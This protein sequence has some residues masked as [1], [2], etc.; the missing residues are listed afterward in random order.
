MSLFR[1]IFGKTSEEA[2]TL[3][4]PVAPHLADSA[5]ESN[6]QGPAV[7]AELSEDDTE[8]YP[9]GA[10]NKSVREL[11]TQQLNSEVLPTQ[12]GLL[13]FGQVTDVGLV[14][15]NNQDAILTYFFTSESSIEYPDFGL[16]IVADGMGGHQEGEKASAI[17]VREIATYM[18]QSLFIPMISSKSENEMLP[19]SE[20]LMEALQ[21]ANREVMENVPDG[22]TTVTAIVI[23]DDLA[24][25]AHIGDSRAYIVNSDGVEQITRD[26][27][28]VQRLIELNQLTREEAENHP[29]KNVL[30]RTLGQ[31]DNVEIDMLTRRL[32]AN[33]RIVICSD[34]LWGQ[35]TERDLYTLSVTNTDPQ[36]IAEKLVDLAKENGGTDN[37][38]VIILKIS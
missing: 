29:Q 38:S 37:I 26:H 8:T 22:G 33:S 2:E 28:L 4:K 25:V 23:M 1:R 36:V 3:E 14:R 21:R 27:S 7:T 31:N 15:S 18:M 11:V 10:G 35:I 20:A 13:T 9:I 34:G 6:N 30:Y 5:N 17:A 24:Y 16:F 12:S 19:V 32:H